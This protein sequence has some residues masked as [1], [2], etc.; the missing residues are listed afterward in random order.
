MTEEPRSYAGPAM[1]AAEPPMTLDEIVD[2]AGR[3]IATGLILAGAFVGLGIYWQPAPP[4]FQMIASG[5]QILRIDTRKGTIIG[6]EGGRCTTVLR[7]GDHLSPRVTVSA[8]P[9][10]AAI[11]APAAPPAPASPPAPVAH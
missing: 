7:H 11:P 9:K 4:R 1:P 10:P 2:R 8:G 5:N 6:C 3:R